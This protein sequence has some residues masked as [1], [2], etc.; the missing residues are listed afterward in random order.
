MFFFVP[1]QF[2]IAI[3]MYT[4]PI[5]I[6]NSLCERLKQRLVVISG[7][8]SGSILIETCY[9]CHI[10][11]LNLVCNVYLSHGDNLYFDLNILYI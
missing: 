5:F 10:L 4:Y 3:Y 9:A 6:C 8:F 11:H 1:G 2:S 7:L